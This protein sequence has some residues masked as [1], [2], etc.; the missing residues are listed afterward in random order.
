MNIRRQQQRILLW[1]YGYV[2]QREKRGDDL[3]VRIL[4]EGVS[5]TPEQYTPAGRASLSRSLE[6]MEQRGLLERI[7]PRGRTVRVKL[8]A[9]GRMFARQFRA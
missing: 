8:T 9:V 4:T 7:R 5:W 3:A 1:L 6:R 2:E